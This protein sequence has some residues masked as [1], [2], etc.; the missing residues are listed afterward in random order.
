M[1]SNPKNFANHLIIAV[2]Q[3]VIS[4]DLIKKVMKKLLKDKIITSNEYER[5]FQCFENLSD[6]QLPTVVLISN[7]L[8][9]NCAYFQIDTK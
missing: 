1:D 7:I 8:Q 6:E 3:L 5:N 2:G 4:R 9:K